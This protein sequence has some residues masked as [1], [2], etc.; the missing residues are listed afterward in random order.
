MK[1]DYKILVF[2]SLIVLNIWLFLI[3]KSLNS[4]ELKVYF[5]DVGQGD[6]I[7]IETKEKKQ[8]L[9]DGGPD[10]AVIQRLSEAMP[11]WDRTIDLVILTHPEADHLIGLIEVLKRYKVAAILESG[12]ECEK[13]HCF[14]WLKE[15]GKEEALNIAAKL[16]QEIVLDENT[17]MAILHPF[18][19]LNGKKISQ[20]N[21]AS[22]VAK[23]IFGSLD[24]GYSFLLTGDIE[25]QVERKLILAGINIDADYLKT[26]HHGS[27]TS[28]SGEFLDNVSPLSAFISLGLDNRYGHPHEEVISRLENKSVKYYR[29]DE[30][31]T[32]LLS[33]KLDEPC[34]IEF[35]K[36]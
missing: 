16:G 28:T 26:P 22:V 34:Q 18:E 23:L 33:C 20:A 13:P 4:E 1:K 27:K 6:S 25:E 17:K 35:R 36:Q 9:I 21:N 24:G 15:K 31:G 11:F 12:V 7:F 5:F 8:I 30:L 10:N 2:L 19:S 32:I 14:S 3:F 29:T